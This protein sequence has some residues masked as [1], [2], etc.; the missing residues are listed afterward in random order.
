MGKKKPHTAVTKNIRKVYSKI[1]NE[2]NEIKKTIEDYLDSGILTEKF[3][4][5]I[6]RLPDNFRVTIKYDGCSFFFYK[7]SYQIIGNCGLEDKIKK[8]L[9]YLQDH[10]PPFPR[11]FNETYDKVL[12]TDNKKEKLKILNDY[13]MNLPERVIYKVIYLDENEIREEKKAIE[14]CRIGKKIYFRKGN[15][16]PSK[17]VYDKETVYEIFDLI[18]AKKVYNS[19]VGLCNQ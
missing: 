3:L 12:N 10:L 5:K 15:K 19:L 13:F 16:I 6:S 1:G 17:K 7:E 14:Y 8:K 11:K 4:H 9:D 2:N 18:K